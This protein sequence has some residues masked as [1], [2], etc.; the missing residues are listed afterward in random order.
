MRLRK[1]LVTQ[2]ADKNFLRQLSNLITKEFP[3]LSA[4]MRTEELDRT[5]RKMILEGRSFGMTWERAL[6]GFV[7]LRLRFGQRFT[8]HPVV[9]RILRD[10]GILGDEKIKALTAEMTDQ[11]WEE[12]DGADN[13]GIT[14]K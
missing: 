3:Q 7:L 9:Q 6:V 12:C 5:I 10:P 8:S 1:E 14:L 13:K 2:M 4:G 11:D